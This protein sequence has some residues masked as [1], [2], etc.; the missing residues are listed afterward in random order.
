MADADGV[1]RITELRTLCDEL[2]SIEPMPPQ[3]T[4]AA[5]DSDT[6]DGDQQAGVE[7]EEA[8]RDAG[9]SAPEEVPGP[10]SRRPAD[11]RASRAAARATQGRS[12]RAI[13]DRT[14]QQ[15]RLAA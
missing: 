6:D 15:V 10:T 4:A 9:T 3:Q 14:N 1:A 2:G 11:A 7:W 5:S 13:R 8:E 12:W